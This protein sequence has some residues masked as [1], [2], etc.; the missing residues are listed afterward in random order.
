MATGKQEAPTTASKVERSAIMAGETPVFRNVGN[1]DNTDA[2]PSELRADM[3]TTQLRITAVGGRKVVTGVTLSPA[4]ASK[5]VGATQQLTATVAPADAALKTVQ[6]S[7]S[8][9]ARATVSSTGLVTAVS[10]G[11]AVITVTTD[12]QKKTATSTIT[13]TAA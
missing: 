7:S 9:P 3:N 5:V 11:T 8:N 12:D 10:A 2:I 13:V 6:Y 1:T 4:T